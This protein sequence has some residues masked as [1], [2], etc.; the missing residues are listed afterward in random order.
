[1]HVTRRA[2]RLFRE[3]TERPEVNLR[4]PLAVIDWVSMWA[5]AVNEENATGGRVVTA[6]TNGAAGILP[7]V[8]HY[9]VQ[10]RGANEDRIVRF[11]LTAGAIG[12]SVQAER[13]HFRRRSRLSGRSGCGLFHGGGSVDGS[14]GRHRAPG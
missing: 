10:I 2:P 5:M 1:M 3:L 14:L 6:P 9:L 12:I 11:L 7:A 8:L 13:L 4:D